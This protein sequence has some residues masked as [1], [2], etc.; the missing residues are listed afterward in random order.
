MPAVTQLFTDPYMVSVF[1]LHNSL[2]A[3]WAARHPEKSCP[4]ELTYLRTLDDGSP[5]SGIF[6]GWPEDLTEFKLMDPCCGSGHFLVGAFLMLVPMRMALE[7]LTVQKAIDAVLCDNLHGLEIDRRCVEIAA[8]ALAFEAWRYPDGG[9]YRPLPPL[10]LAW[11][12][13]PISGKKKDWLQLV[14]NDDR[15]CAGMEAL[16]DTFRDAPLL[17]SLIDPKR[18]IKE[19]MLT[20]GYEE[21]KPVLEK[22]LKDHIGE[23]VIEERAIA[24]QGISYAAE[25]LSRTYNLVITNVPYLARS[26]QHDKLKNF[27]DEN[28]IISKNDIASA[29]L[30]RCLQ[31]SDNSNITQIV[32]PQ[33]WLSQAAY[34]KFRKHLLL[35]HSWL[36]LVRLGS[37]AFESISGEVVNVILFTIRSDNKF[38]KSNYIALDVSGSNKLEEKISKLITEDLICI[39]QSKYKSDKDAIIHFNTGLNFPS[40]DNLVRSYQGIKSGDDNYFCKMFWELNNLLN[41]EWRFEQSTANESVHYEGR[42]KIIWW[43]KNKQFARL[44]GKSG[45]DKQGIII[46]QMSNLYSTLHTGNLFDGTVTCLIPNDMNLLTAL[47]CYCSSN[48]YVKAIRKIEK[49]VAVSNSVLAKAPIDL[50]YWQKVSREKYPNGLPKPYSDD[51]TQWINHGHPKPSTD[52]LQ[53]AVARLLGYQWPAE[54]DDQMEISE[55]THKWIQKAKEL[56][57]YMDDDGI[58]CLPANHGELPAHERLLQLLIAAWG[59]DWHFGVLEQLLTDVGCDGK[60]LNVWLRDKFFEQHCALFHHRPFIWHVW[61]GLKD[62]FAALINYHKLDKNILER[63]I[64]SYLGD[65]IRAQ[66]SD[67]R[68]RMDGAGE[69]LSAARLLKDRLEMILKGEAPLDIFVR[70]KPIEEQPIGWEPDLNDGVR[71]NIRPFMVVE[72]IGKKSAGIL[73]TKPNIHWKKHQ[74]KDVESA[75]WYPLFKGERI[76][77]HHLTI[78]EKQHARTDTKGSAA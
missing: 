57:K 68:N 5:A 71:L 30:D 31:L 17:G 62:G 9:N 35:D 40:L 59:D 7:G 14:G 4:I 22:A 43:S 55:E 66:E 6:D 61:D 34:I 19:D 56:N 44:Q 48:E 70:W 16:Y 76:N 3:W 53:V 15:L 64:Y 49:G 69:R 41:D 20:A 11:C 60:T 29:F 28:Y 52:P 47:W 72:D 18:A 63:L 36:L 78:I 74:G 23:D 54:L 10:N 45:W 75:P 1:I 50:T 42:E 37:G 33:N 65:W 12:G 39:D 58:V 24:A 77:D 32:M 2:G 73:R 27:C 25:M 8:F 67:V 13:Q 21:L 26:K 51:P 46:N 38:I